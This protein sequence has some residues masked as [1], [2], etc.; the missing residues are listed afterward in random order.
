[1]RARRVPRADRP[2]S[3]RR[4]RP[5]STSGCSSCRTGDAAEAAAALPPRRPTLDPS[6]GEAWHALGAALVERRRAGRDRRLA[7]RRAAAAAR[8]RSAVQSGDGAR[9]QP[10]ARRGASVSAALRARGA[11]RQVRGDIAHVR[12]RWRAC[13]SRSDDEAAA[14]GSAVAVLVLL[15]V[16][17]GASACGAAGRG[18]PASSRSASRRA[19]RRERAARHHRHAARRSRRRLRQPARA[20]ADARSARRAKGVRFEPRLRARAA[21][22]AVARH[23]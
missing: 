6:Y 10:H 15:A 17:A 2:R 20:D 18:R 3:G 5:G 23:R 19:A 16:A 7:P 14:P 22:A 13:E 11:A 21:D 4:R 8:L 12:R 1:M 9:R